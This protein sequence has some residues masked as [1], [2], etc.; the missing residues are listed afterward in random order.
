[1]VAVAKVFGWMELVVSLLAALLCAEAIYDLVTIDADLAPGVIG[2][3]LPVSLSLAWGGWHLIKHQDWMHQAA[4]LFVV[5]AI[6]SVFFG[7]EY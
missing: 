1:M 3:T 4:P 5:F 2:I 7:I 6:A